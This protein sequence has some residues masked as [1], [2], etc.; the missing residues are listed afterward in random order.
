MSVLVAS[1]A[2]DTGVLHKPDP[3]SQNWTHVH[4]DQESEKLETALAVSVVLHT[5]EMSEHIRNKI[6]ELQS[7]SSLFLL[8]SAWSL[9]HGPF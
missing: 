8:K 2:G 7:A 9:S 3:S 1:C 5:S 6:F 4:K